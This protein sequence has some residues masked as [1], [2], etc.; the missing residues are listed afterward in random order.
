MLQAHPLPTH[1][2]SHSPTP[3]SAWACWGC[4]KCWGCRAILLDDPANSLFNSA[5][6]TIK[7]LSPNAKV[8]PL[9]QLPP[10]SLKNFLGRRLAGAAPHPT[11]SAGQLCC[12]WASQEHLH[13]AP[14]DAGVCEVGGLRRAPVARMQCEKWGN[15]H[16]NSGAVWR[17]ALASVR[18]LP[19][20]KIWPR[21][22]RPVMRCSAATRAGSAQHGCSCAL[23]LPSSLL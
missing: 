11:A 18:A 1:C 16:G 20:I 5:V 12:V 9:T 8:L 2:C 3:G 15:I 22:A 14:E 19:S 23:P 13:R 7:P 10:S 17:S 21:S 4:P 6:T